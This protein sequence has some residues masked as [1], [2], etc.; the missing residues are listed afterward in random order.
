MKKNQEKE[1]DEARSNELQELNDKLVK[2]EADMEH[3]KN[4]YYQAYAD[5][6]NL[7]KD[8]EK[9]GRNRICKRHHC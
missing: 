4:Q 2:A 7:R 9:D 3:W 6:A 1:V 8:I 5:M